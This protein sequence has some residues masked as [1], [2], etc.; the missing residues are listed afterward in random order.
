MMNGETR[1][2]ARDNDAARAPALCLR[3][4]LPTEILADERVTKIIA[5]AENGSFCLLPRHIDFV[6]ALA[7]GILSMT[8]QNGR[9]EF[10]AVDRGILVKCGRD[11]F[12]STPHAVRGE[13]LETLKRAVREQ[14]HQLDERERTARSAL[15]RLEADFV[16]R[17]VELR[18]HHG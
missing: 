3:V 7:P 5:H 18:E 9:E 6:A 16:R 4:L 11:V 13:K 10:I 8:K 12:V 2:S 14:F 1:L 17:F 15:S